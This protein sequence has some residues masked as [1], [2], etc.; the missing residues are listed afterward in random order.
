MDIFALL[1]SPLLGMISMLVPEAKPVIN[2]IQSHSDIIAKAAPVVQA[3][4]NEGKPAF[5]AALQHAPQLATAV[6]SFL[7]QHDLP[8]SPPGTPASQA[9]LN[10]T[11]KALVGAAK[12]NANDASRQ[13]SG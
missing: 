3:A 2:F 6:K 13:G 7:Q 5:D 11:T 4:I 12:P 1:N 10:S 8:G 9:V